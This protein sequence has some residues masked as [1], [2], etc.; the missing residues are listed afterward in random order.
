MNQKH[1]AIKQLDKLFGDDLC[2][3]RRQLSDEISLIFRHAPAKYGRE[4]E[5]ILWRRKFYDCCKEFKMCVKLNKTVCELLRWHIVSGICHYHS[6]ILSFRKLFKLS[7]LDRLIF[8]PLSDQ[9]NFLGSRFLQL[10][11]SFD[12]NLYQMDR[13]GP[14]IFEDT[15]YSDDYEDDNDDDDVIV[16]QTEF[17]LVRIG[18]SNVSDDDEELSSEDNYEENDDEDFE[19]QKETIHF[20]VYRFFICIG[21]LARYYVDVFVQDKERYDNQYYKIALLYYRSASFLQPKFGMPYNQLGSLHSYNHYGLDSLYS[22][23]R[24]L[25]M[26]IKYEGNAAN[27]KKIFNLQKRFEMNWRKQTKNPLDSIHQTNG[28]LTNKIESDVDLIRSTILGL[29]RIF[30]TIYKFIQELDSDSDNVSGLRSSIPSVFKDL[31]VDIKELLIQFRRSLNIETSLS[32]RS[33]PNRLTFENIIN[34][35]SI[36]IILVDQIKKRL[37]QKSIEVSLMN[38]YSEESYTMSDDSYRNGHCENLLLSIS[39]HFLF[40][41]MTMII[42]RESETLKKM[43]YVSQNLMDDNPA[44][45]TMKSNR[46]SEQKT[47]SEKR[48]DQNFSDQND[49]SNLREFMKFKHSFSSDFAAAGEIVDETMSQLKDTVYQTIQD[50]LDSS[51]ED[52]NDEYDNN[53][54][55][56]QDVDGLIAKTKKIYNDYLR[57]SQNRLNVQDGLASSSSST[58]S[59]SASIESSPSPPNSHPTTEA[60][61]IDQILFWIYSDHYTPMIK[62]FCDYLQSNEDFTEILDNIEAILEYFQYF[63]QYLNILSDFDWRILINF[64]NNLDQLFHRNCNTDKIDFDRIYGLINLFDYINQISKESLKNF[65]QKSPLSFEQPLLNLTNDLNE[66]YRSIFNCKD[67]NELMNKRL[68]IFPEQCGYFCVRYLIVFGIKL[69]SL[70]LNNDDFNMSMINFDYSTIHSFK[71]NKSIRF[72]FDLKKKLSQS[73]LKD[74]NRFSVSN[75]QKQLITF[76]SQDLEGAQIGSDSASKSLQTSVKTILMNSNS[77]PLKLNSKNSDTNENQQQNRQET[78]SNNF[79]SKKVINDLERLPYAIFD[80]ILY[81]ENLDQIK[82]IVSNKRS[83]VIVPRLV[84]DYLN[85]MKSEK[86]SEANE[87]TNFLAEEFLRGSRLIRFIRNEDRL[88]LE[89]MNY[90]HNKRKK[91]NDKLRDRNF[92][93]DLLEHCHYLLANKILLNKNISINDDID[94][95][96][97]LEDRSNVQIALV[98]DDVSKWPADIHKRIPQNFG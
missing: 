44:I 52:S 90:T 19:E 21:D 70:S 17:D 16:K 86:T 22:Y 18:P 93:Y 62:F 56:H 74:E 49:R 83:F 68:L 76:D 14:K 77:K 54:R 30:S 73:I 10:N 51:E 96:V 57:M 95:A 27:L 84:I 72:R 91:S 36:I 26:E 87:A 33:E 60:K 75:Q 40:Q 45:V 2:D 85:E 28:Y 29:S 42:H 12:W 31:I 66:F 94:G 67:E 48:K 8:L 11:D 89:T 37:K 24:S 65:R 82:T 23:F 55:D 4:C 98:T 69:I 1:H 3:L 32:S 71:T 92:F 38:V 50:V 46:S 13:S 59:I 5:D 25:S 81:L 6:L 20:L 35:I 34:L 61:T 63:Y 53:E 7:Y 9:N 41:M 39:Y 78:A 47:K 80:P 43:L 79:N 64:N 58:S 88:E 15:A 97:R